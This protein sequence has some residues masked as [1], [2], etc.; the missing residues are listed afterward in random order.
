VDWRNPD[1]GRIPLRRGW[2]GELATDERGVFRA[3]L[4]GLSQRLQQRIGEIYTAGCRAD[5]GD[6]LCRVDLAAFTRSGTVESATSR[7]GVVAAPDF[8]LLGPSA[9][10][11]GY[12]GDT[13]VF[14]TGG[15]AGRAF[16]V[17][18]YTPCSRASCS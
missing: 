16:E 17:L 18:A 1:A 6:H 3:E 10:P 14:E 9:A 5:L 12:D 8:P 2:L 13:L 11:N 4:S 7:R 15:N